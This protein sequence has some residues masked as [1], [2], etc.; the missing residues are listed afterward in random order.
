M[1]TKATYQSKSVT[2]VRPAK[3]GDPGFNANLGK[4][5]V[6][7][8]ADGTEKTVAETEVTEAE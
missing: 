3:Q 4:Q 2:I 1:G 8:L 5:L 6:I 7:K